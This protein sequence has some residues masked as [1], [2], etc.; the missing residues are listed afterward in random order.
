VCSSD[1]LSQGVEG[2]FSPLQSL[3]D[4]HNTT[5]TNAMMN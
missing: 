1:L 3:F 5:Q 2:Y 4:Q